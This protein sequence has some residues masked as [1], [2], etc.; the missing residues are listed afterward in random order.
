MLEQHIKTGLLN[1]HIGYQLLLPSFSPE[2]LNPS[3]DIPDSLP[4]LFNPQLQVLR[5]ISL[6]DT[7]HAF[8]FLGQIL[9]QV[10]V[11]IKC[12]H[13]ALELS[14][15]DLILWT[16]DASTLEDVAGKIVFVT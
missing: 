2:T 9:D 8:K 14:C 7:Y 6:N 15:L 4:F 16:A 5:P 11:Y 1:Q 12:S 10:L 3:H 13:K